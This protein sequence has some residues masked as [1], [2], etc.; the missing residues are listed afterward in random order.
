[1]PPRDRRDDLT[2]A[3][4]DVLGDSGA[5]RVQAEQQL[6]VADGEL[7]P[8][9]Y[10]AG[11]DASNAI[12][13][14]VDG[15]GRVESID[16]NRNWRERLA[17]GEFAGALF[18]AY[19]AAVQKSLAAA[20]LAAHAAE[21]AEP[22][23]QAVQAGTRQQDGARQRH[24]ENGNSDAERELDDREWLAATWDVL[25]GVDAELKRLARIEA[26]G[27]A[28]ADRDTSVSS[29]HGYLTVRLRGRGVVGIS[30]DV[31]RI[32]VADAERLRW[33]ALAMFRAARL[34]AER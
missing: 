17:V 28:A 31:R 13:V 4:L 12:S 10:Y 33:D 1:M 16:I 8:S 6:R 18:G 9:S 21:Q 27:R 19:T 30:G 24:A 20:A 2:L 32:A 34:T 25:G 26:E 11:A 29:P 3:S 23:G 15:R 22:A 5:L 14:S 7:R